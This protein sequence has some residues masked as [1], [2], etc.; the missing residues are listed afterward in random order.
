MTSLVS[1]QYATL[2][3][4]SLDIGQ[5][6][7]GSVGAF[8]HLYVRYRNILWASRYFFEFRILALVDITNQQFPQSVD[9]SS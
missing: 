9:G 7:G 6:K 3:Y 8:N 2:L 4:L 5:K 1:C